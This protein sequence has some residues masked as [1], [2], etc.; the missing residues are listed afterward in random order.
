MR[1]PGCNTDN[2]PGRRF[3]AGCG[4]PL[5]AGCPACGFQNAPDDR[6]CGGCGKPLHAAAPG[7]AGA[8]SPEASAPE[9]WPPET[10]SGEI[11]PVTVMFVDISGYTA[12]S[13]RLDAEDTHRLLAR[14]FETVDAIVVRFG[15]RIDK[16]IGDSVMALFGA[17]ISHG[18]DP[19]RAMLAAIAIHAAMPALSEAVGHR[20]KVHIGIATGEVI[21]SGLGSSAHSAYTVIGDAVNL[22]ARLMERAAA[23]ETLASTSVWDAAAHAAS[24]AGLAAEPLGAVTYRGIARPVETCRIVALQTSAP[25]AVA[26]PLVGRNAELGLLA[27]LMDSALHGSHGATVVLRGEPGI[28]KTRLADALFDLAAERGFGALK[29]LVLDFGSGRV[30]SVE[31]SLANGLLAARSF[32]QAL[33]GQIS[34]PSGGSAAEP[35]ID[36]A[37]LDAA[38]QPYLW[39]LLDLPQPEASRATYEAMSNAARNAGKSATLA[40]LVAGTAASRPLLLLIEDVHWSDPVLRG[41]IAAMAEATARCRAMLVMT[42]RIEGDPFD[43][44]FRA[45]LKQAR[46][47]VLDLAPLG[48]EE[49]ARLAQTLR[50]EFDDFSRRCI[51]RAEGN[52]LFLEQLLRS[53][54]GQERLPETVQSVVLARLDQLPPLDRQALQAASV[55]GQHFELADLSTLINR[56]DYDPGELLRRQLVRP[57][58]RGLLFAHALIRDGAYASLTRERR[59]ALHRAAAAL[60]GA[61]DLPLH[62]EHLDRA[63]DAGAAKAYLKAAEDEA[64]AYRLNRALDLAER[65]LRVA[66]AAE[67]RVALGLAAGRF[68]LDIGLAKPARAA[69]AVAASSET[70]RDRCRAL[71]GLAAAD[72]MQGE[73]SHA[74]GILGD[75]E[76]IAVELDDPALLAEIC[77]LRGNLHFALGKAD[78]CL[79]E[80]RRALIAAKRA[81]LP[82]WK[83]RAR[84]GIGDA[85]YMQGRF[86]S[87]AREFLRA[88]EIAKTNNLLRIVG[89]N[90][91]MAGNTAFYSLEFESAF[92]MIAESGRIALAIGDRFGDMFAHECR[93]IALLWLG[94]WGELG[95][96]AT[97]ALEKARALG[98]RRYESLLLPPLAASLFMEGRHDEAE[99][100]IR[101]AMTISEETGT[102]FCGAIICGIA[103]KVERDP[104]RRAA[105]LVRGEALLRE[106]GI[107]HNHIWF[108]IFA[109]DRALADRDWEGVERQIGRL[110]QYTA[111][112]PLPIV[113][114]MLDRAR[115]LMRLAGDPEDAAALADLERLRKT[116]AE[117]GLN[118]DLQVPERNLTRP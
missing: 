107:S 109:I 76:P 22:A 114:L 82:E 64:A 101:E 97:V 118:L 71:I 35:A 56:R 112:E 69:F 53:A 55:L 80:H 34:T 111:A 100:A 27:S 12:L 104:Q 14:F 32:E 63:D 102:G 19:E 84:S 89:A 50:S 103:A 29:A 70:P 81:A 51:Q 39:D 92:D 86:R 83:A 66:K 17:P 117:A 10:P 65:G 2:R 79:S 61:R 73:A 58:D 43:A 85:Y 115:A 106:T 75:A 78:E 72:R 49:A 74:M 98:A 11:R 116:A 62:A 7:P 4:Q 16:H 108:R 67:D 99:Q 52:P 48:P 20:L 93:T 13:G 45:G 87:S 88:V 5:P 23:E 25:K 59:A 8:A 90:L 24:A 47:T 28:G 30:G 15:G 91:A 1:C 38:E 33:L 41:H 3:C 57:V 113:E 18:N 60:Y 40:K 94:R 95:P 110:A 9:T 46:L 105:A 42:T 54:A 77:Y 31:R 6:F 44:G 36:H 37:D 68:A 26:R 21:A 96:T